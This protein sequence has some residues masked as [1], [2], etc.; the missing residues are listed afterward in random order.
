[1]ETA[2]SLDCTIFHNLI[3]YD[4]LQAVCGELI[5]ARITVEDC[6]KVVE[7]RF[8]LVILAAERARQ[9]F[10]GDKIAV[11]DKDEK[12]AVIALREIA[13]ETVSIEK[14]KEKA[15]EKFRSFTFE[16]ELDE[17]LEEL[18]ETD[19]Y[20][21]CVELAADALESTGVSIVDESE[22]DTDIC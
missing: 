9:I 15:I 3:K 1:M 7:N 5:M 13:D 10:A 6:E 21:P 19:T 12:K 20:S 11:E 14:L 4:M 18:M 8:D 16:E 17:N 2:L 22:I